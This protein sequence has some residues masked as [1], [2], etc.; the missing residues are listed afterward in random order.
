MNGQSLAC[1]SSSSRA[2]CR[3]ARAFRPV[4]VGNFLRQPGHAFLRDLQVRINPF[5]RFVQPRAPVTFLAP[6]RR[7]GRG[8]LIGRMA[9]QIFARRDERKDLLVVKNFAREIIQKLRPFI[10]PMAE[11]FRVVRRD[12]QRRAVQ[13]AGDALGLFDALVE[14][15]PGV[16]AR[17]LQGRGR[18]GK[19]ACPRPRR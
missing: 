18:A 7:A 19:S 15:M 1:A 2:A 17:R 11:Q 4:A 10:P 12:D 6:A 14:K 3:N 16:L 8:D 5:V 9:V 13:K